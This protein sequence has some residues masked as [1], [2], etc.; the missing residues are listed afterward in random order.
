MSPP[1][2]CVNQFL[3]A[4]GRLLLAAAALILEGVN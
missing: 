3:A 2:N 1:R 4:A